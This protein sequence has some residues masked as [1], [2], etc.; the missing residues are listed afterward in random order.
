MESSVSCIQSYQELRGISMVTAIVD[1]GDSDNSIIII[2]NNN[3]NNNNNSIIDTKP[4]K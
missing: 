2:N 3:N 1:N 4:I